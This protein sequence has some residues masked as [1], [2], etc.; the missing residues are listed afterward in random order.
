MAAKN[1]IEFPRVEGEASR[2]AHADL[3]SGTYEREIGRDGFF[4]PATHIYHK[5]PPTGWTAFDG[6]LR[7]RAFDAV[8]AVERGEPNRII[9]LLSNANCKVD[10]WRCLAS[11]PTLARNADGDL[12]FFIHAGE[13]DLFCDFGHLPYRE[14]DYILLPRG[15]MWRLETK[16]PTTVLRIEATNGSYKLPERGILGPHAIFDPAA[17]ETPK[18]DDTFKSQRDGEWIVSVKR[19]GELTRITYPFNPLDAVG[20]KGNLTA[21]KLNWRDIRPVMSHRYHIPPSVHSTFVADRFVVCTFVPRPIESDPGAL[22]VPFYHSNDDYDEV[23]FYH[24]G[25]F[26][27]RDNIHPGMVTWHPNGFTHG[28]HPKAFAAGQKAAKTMTDEVAVMIDSRDPL[29]ML[30]AAEGTEDRGY[31]DSWKSKP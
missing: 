9:P 1:W 28:P 14:G 16:Q 11:M 17:L 7:P 3:P 10:I 24:Q 26:F 8:K 2:Q 6:P 5:H 19:R 20:W 15:T 27:S 31:A 25:E 23:I 29:D 21:L 12:L 4:G 13:G 18:L 22:K 30:A